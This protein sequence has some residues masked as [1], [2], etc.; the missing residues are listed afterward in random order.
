MLGI[1]P[2]SDFEKTLQNSFDFV[3]KKH[4]EAIQFVDKNQNKINY[5]HSEAVMLYCYGLDPTQFSIKK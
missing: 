2:N 3:N 5:N 1:C 4:I